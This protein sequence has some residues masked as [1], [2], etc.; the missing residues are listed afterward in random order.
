MRL[1]FKQKVFS[2]R[3]RSEIFDESGNVM[4]TA[5]G[6]ILSLG[7]KMHILDDMNNEIAFVQQRLLRLLPRFSVYI[8][9][10]FIGDVV[11]QFT[12]L[13][14]HYTIDELGWQISGDFFEHDYSISC[15]GNYIAS[16]H[17]RWMSWGDSFEIDV[18]KDQDI[19][20]ALAV[21]IAIDCVIDQSQNSY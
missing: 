17:K 16:I 15:G 21:I 11:K 1:Y 2:F 13:K 4:F 3:Q 18:A 12:L 10:Q 7:R 8:G 9:G 6:E 5:V 20:M 14:P 19:V